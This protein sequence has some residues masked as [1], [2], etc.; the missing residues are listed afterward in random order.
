MTYKPMCGIKATLAVLV[1]LIVICGTCAVIQMRCAAPDQLASEALA[2]GTW[3]CLAV[4]DKTLEP[5]VHCEAKAYSK[6]KADAQF[7][8]LYKCEDKCYMDCKIEACIRMK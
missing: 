6:K 2:P 4:A 8:A 7:I 3:V 1:G 5:D